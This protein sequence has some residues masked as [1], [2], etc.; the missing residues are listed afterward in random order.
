MSTAVD[1]ATHSP[2]TGPG[3]FGAVL[4]VLPPEIRPLTDAVRNVVVHYRASGIDFPAERLAEVNLRWADSMLE[5]DQERFGVPLAE[6]RPEADRLVGC[7]RDFTLLTVAALR[8]HGVAARSR[9]GFAS[10]LGDGWHYDHVIAE[11]RDGDQWRFADAQLDPGRDWPFDPSDLPRLVGAD[12][13]SAPR[14]ETAAQV[15]LAFRRGDLDGE[16]Y[17]VA[18]GLPFRGGWFIRNYVIQEL[19]H[20]HKDELLLWDGWGA[21]SDNLDGDLAKIDAIA[22][23]LL[24]ADDGDEAAERELSTRYAADPDLRPGAKIDCRSPVGAPF[25]VDLNRG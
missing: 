22:A 23:L 21:M 1:L 6:P 5:R 15:W 11:Y 14:F 16:R 9:I 2:Y 18:P 12:P 4:D 7:C 3:R 13:A 8:Q 24:A 17:G 25:T 19:A 20:R 10:Y